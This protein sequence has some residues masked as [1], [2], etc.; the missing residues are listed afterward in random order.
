MAIYPSGNGLDYVLNRRPGLHKAAKP[1]LKNHTEALHY[2]PIHMFFCDEP[3][4]LFGCMNCIQTFYFLRK[5]DD[6][7]YPLFLSWPVNYS[8]FYIICSLFVISPPVT[9]L[10]LVLL[11]F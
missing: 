4:T 1:K 10:K 11:T 3:Y 8:K 2:V 5:D 6:F 7:K 9:C